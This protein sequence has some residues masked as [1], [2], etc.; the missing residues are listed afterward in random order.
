MDDRLD[1]PNVESLDMVFVSFVSQFVASGAL[2]VVQ[3]PRPP[4]ALN[5]FLSMFQARKFFKKQETWHPTV[6]AT[7]CES[8]GQYQLRFPGPLNNEYFSFLHFPSS[9]QC[10]F[11]QRLRRIPGALLGWTGGCP[12]RTRVSPAYL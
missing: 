5:D 11:V 6:R 12:K 2:R 4:T 9:Y 3:V 1:F 7:L 10:R 8:S